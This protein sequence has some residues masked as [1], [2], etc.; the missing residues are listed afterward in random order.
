MRNSE[1][2]FIL[3]TGGETACVN[4]QIHLHINSR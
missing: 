3:L 1:L 2:S 4:K